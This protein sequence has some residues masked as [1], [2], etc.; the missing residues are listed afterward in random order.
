MRTVRRPLA[1][2]GIVIHGDAI[3]TKILVA[4]N[5]AVYLI[6]VGQGGGLNDPG[7]RLFT[8]WLLYGPAVE[9][10]DWW[11]LLTATFLH[12]GIWH[13]AVNMYALWWLG[14]AV[15][16]AIGSVR[17]LLLYFASGLAGSAGAL[18]WSP[19]ALTVGASGAI[20]GMLGA[21]L[22]LEWRATGRLVGGFAV[23]LLIN[24][25]FT[26]G[27][28]SFISV[29]GHVGG[30]IGG[31]IGTAVIVGRGRFRIPWDVPTIV[32]LAAVGAAS[33]VVA[34]FKVRGLA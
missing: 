11:R 1:R 21:G 23:M 29:G 13:I 4:L 17:F 33:I 18:V 24:L 12:A 14:S 7:G 6:T 22:I 9:Q 8:K 20:F 19:N 2:R 27:F 34:Y 5:V 32:G 10:G 25:A 26:F 3:V 30:L 16:G 31:L 28:S 15:E